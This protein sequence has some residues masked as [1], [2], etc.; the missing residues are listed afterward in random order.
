MGNAFNTCEITRRFFDYCPNPC[1]VLNQSQN[2][3]A[4]TTFLAGKVG[5][6][7]LKHRETRPI[8][9]ENR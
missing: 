8:L 5:L 4:T 7:A 6:C 9:E 2:H 3:H 1:A